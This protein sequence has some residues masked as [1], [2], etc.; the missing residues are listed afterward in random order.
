MVTPWSYKAMRPLGWEKPV[1]GT[2]LWGASRKSAETREAQERRTG[3]LL[4]NHA[5]RLRHIPTDTGGE[6]E[7]QRTQEHCLPHT[8]AKLRQWDINACTYRVRK[9]VLNNKNTHASE[10]MRETHTHIPTHLSQERGTEGSAI[11][12][13]SQ[14]RKRTG[15]YNGR[16]AAWT[17]RKGQG[18]KEAWSP[19]REHRTHTQTQR[20]TT[21]GSQV[22]HLW[23]LMRPNCTSSWNL[24]RYLSQHLDGKCFLKL[25]WVGWCV[26]VLKTDMILKSWN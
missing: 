24:P 19:H 6:S 3:Q 16:V 26:C 18:D 9:T 7:T 5:D 12:K 21:L 23:L 11:Q 13:H 22:S 25:P 1:W 15:W 10:T 2:T 14:S 4:G 20:Q 17:W 8:A